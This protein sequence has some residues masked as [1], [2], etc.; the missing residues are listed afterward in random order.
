MT[1]MTAQVFFVVAQAKDAVIVPVS[2]LRP[3]G[4]GAGERRRAKEGDA[5]T[6]DAKASGPPDAA[7][8]SKGAGASAKGGGRSRAE[9]GFDPRTRFSNG[10]AI[11]RVVKAD[12]TLENREV[13]VGVMSRVSAQ[14]VAG[15]EPGEKIVTGQAQSASAP[16]AQA[17]GNNA[18]R[19]QPRI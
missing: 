13:Q 16:K 9:G 6:A 2:A 8:P 17:K 3:V 14:I 12:G 19:M 5:R 18:P 4:G 11:V 1:Q 7:A 10:R 15:L